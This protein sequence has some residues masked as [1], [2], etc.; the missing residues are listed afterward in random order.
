M[1]VKVNGLWVDGTVAEVSASRYSIITTDG[2][3]VSNKGRYEVRLP[4]PKHFGTIQSKTTSDYDWVA[5]RER[6][7]DMSAEERG[8]Q[9]SVLF[10]ANIW[11]CCGG[12][13][14][15]PPCGRK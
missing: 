2:V 11:S 6:W 12:E 15:S 5:F 7:R 1:E 13:W 8:A 3:T 10:G 4:A 14:N 9:E